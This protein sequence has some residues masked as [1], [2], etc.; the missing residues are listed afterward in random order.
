MH[1]SFKCFLSG[2]QTKILYAVFSDLS[3]YVLHVLT[4]LT[5]PEAPQYA[6]SCHFMCFKVE[7]QDA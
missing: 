3:N 4:T 7:T 6:V 1:R 2:F 5:M